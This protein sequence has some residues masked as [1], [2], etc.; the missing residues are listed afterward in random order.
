MRFR[1]TLDGWLTADS[2]SID[3]AARAALG[4]AMAELNGL[5]GRNAAID[6]NSRT[7]AIVISCV[8]EAESPVHAVQPASDNILLALGQGKIGT[9]EWPGPKAPGWR[10]E[11]VNSRSEQ[12]LTK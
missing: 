11:F 8:V 6:L 5:G 2:G 12:L 4:I 1:V 9:P 3:D 7:G 10:V